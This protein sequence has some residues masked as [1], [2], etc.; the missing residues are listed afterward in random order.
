VF[1]Y[2]FSSPGAENGL[3]CFLNAINQSAGRR[4]VESVKIEIYSLEFIDEKLARLDRR[5]KEEVF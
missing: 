3:K 5:A 2:L 4:L 1:Q